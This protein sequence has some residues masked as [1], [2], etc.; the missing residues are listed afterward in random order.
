MA[1]GLRTPWPLGLH[2]FSYDFQ[3]NFLS[4]VDFLWGFPLRQ[5]LLPVIAE[6]FISPLLFTITPGKKL[7]LQKVKKI[8]ILG[9]FF[10]SSIL[11][12]ITCIV[13][14]V[15]ELSVLSSEGLPLPDDYSRHHLPELI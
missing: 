10:F 6:P 4:V 9:I 7:I 14:K 1:K 5:N 3:V 8:G 11:F 12:K 2:F 13:L 15:D